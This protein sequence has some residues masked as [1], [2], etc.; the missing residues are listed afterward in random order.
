MVAYKEREF[1]LLACQQT[2]GVVARD[3][4]DILPPPMF[5]TSISPA[6]PLIT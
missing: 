3:M 4:T 2:G 5:F 1:V 6:S